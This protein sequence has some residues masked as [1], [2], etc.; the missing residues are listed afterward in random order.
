MV[1]RQ[2]AGDLFGMFKH[3]GHRSPLPVFSEI[4]VHAIALFVTEQRT[5]IAILHAV[6]QCWLDLLS[7]VD[8]HA[9]SRGQ[10]HKCCFCCAE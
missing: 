5:A 2:L 10:V 6:D 7:A 1:R 9:V 4:T 8:Q 3:G